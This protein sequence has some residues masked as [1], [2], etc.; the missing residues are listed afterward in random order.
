MLI[1]HFLI[2]FVA[3]GSF[4]SSGFAAITVYTS[5]SAWMATSAWS[6]YTHSQTTETFDTYANRSYVSEGSQ[7]GNQSVPI[8]NLNYGSSV[9]SNSATL[10]RVSGG[11]ASSTYNETGGPYSYSPFRV[12]NGTTF[13]INPYGGSG[14]ALSFYK[15]GSPDSFKLSF[16]TG[17]SA[18]SLFLGDLG[19]SANIG[20]PNTRL[21]IWADTVNGA[22]TAVWDSTGRASQSNSLAT[23]QTLTTGNAT[24][25]FLGF[26]SDDPGG[27]TALQF[28]L[29]GNTDDNIMVD[30]LRFNTVPEPSAAS[31]MVLGAGALLALKRRR[32]V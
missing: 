1:R 17:V 31:L 11:I 28:T 18:V 13:G 10:L 29:T 27:I 15:S 3:G 32:G 16:S 8:V 2:F 4:I 14:N 23:G 25:A 30:Q 24:W 6:Q 7:Y 21:Q 12:E 26:S 19:D 20:L 9:P 5:E 22:N